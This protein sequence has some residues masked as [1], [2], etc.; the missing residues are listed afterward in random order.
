MSCAQQTLHARALTR[1]PALIFEFE[2]LTIGFWRW[3][4]DYCHAVS[5]QMEKMQ[6]ELSHKLQVRPQQSHHIEFC[7]LLPSSSSTYKKPFSQLGLLI[8]RKITRP[9]RHV[10]CERERARGEG[11][12]TV[13]LN[14]TQQIV[15]S[16]GIFFCFLCFYA[17][18]FI[19]CC[20]VVMCLL[21]FLVCSVAFII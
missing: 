13:Q 15:F 18:F 9:L 11:Q 16:F 14:F 6:T 12:L 2:Y 5:W 4:Q 17:H 1:S 7:I 8:Q 21:R 10:V 3:S 19:W 20:T